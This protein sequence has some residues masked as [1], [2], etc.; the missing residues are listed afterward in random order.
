[1]NTIYIPGAVII[2]LL[3]YYRYKSDN[4]NKEQVESE[5]FKDINSDIVNDNKPKI[6]TQT[7]P[8]TGLEFKPEI[9]APRNSY[10]YPEDDC[11]KLEKGVVYDS[12]TYSS[13]LIEINDDKELIL[14]TEKEFL[15]AKRKKRR[16]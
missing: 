15:R 5:T 10:L 1:M 7:V 12:K 14:Y 13:E 9:V 2:A 4:L 3:F 11:G 6:V 16:R 8:N